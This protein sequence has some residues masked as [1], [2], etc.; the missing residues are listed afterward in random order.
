[1]AA[2][3]GR[4][5]RNGAALLPAIPAF[6]GGPLLCF[7]LSSSASAQWTRRLE[8][9]HGAFERHGAPD[10]IVHAPPGFDPA[11]PLHVVLFFHGYRG[12]V[13]VLAESGDEVRCRADHPPR[14]GWGLLAR[15]DEAGTHTLFVL[16]QLAFW[17]RD[18]DPG[19]FA[20]PRELRAFVD[21][22]LASIETELGARRTTSDLA[23]ITILAHSA[24][25]ETTLWVLRVGG[26][27]D[28]LRHVVLFDALY[29][30]GPAF[31]DW[32]RAAP[33]RRLV[34]F[35]SR[36][37]PEIRNRDLARRAQREGVPLGRA[38]EAAR[39]RNVVVVETETPHAEIP[40]AHLGATLRALGLPM[41][42]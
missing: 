9:E 13:E 16:A 3:E 21:E 1:V 5:G 25:F 30:G 28:R 36:G 38:L 19:R 14:R 27:E 15:H 35:F 22:V 11:L 2:E 24:A 31:L 42:P 18:G 8:L 12:C 41:R 7:L 29:S 33:E 40:A 32:A 39:D 20:R 34:S 10:A 26:I 23:S 4:K 37:T 6:L 17:R